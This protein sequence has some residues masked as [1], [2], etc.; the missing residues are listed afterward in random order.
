MC[1]HRRPIIR[2]SWGWSIQLK[3]NVWTLWILIYSIIFRG[4]KPSC[5]EIHLIFIHLSS[6]QKLFPENPT[7]SHQSSLNKGA[8][9]TVTI[10]THTHTPT[11]VN[12]PDHQAP[13]IQ[14]GLAGALICPSPE[15]LWK[16]PRSLEASSALES[17]CLDWS[18]ISLT[19]FKETVV[20]SFCW[21]FSNNSFPQRNAYSNTDGCFKD[22]PKNT[23]Q[24]YLWRQTY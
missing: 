16:N 9:S 8:Y 6:S 11:P 7:P 12:V 18:S 10:T 2:C 4:Q 13:R 3:V 14:S 21:G 22:M 15:N 1:F 20:K 5:H 23:H 17:W 24:T 19:N